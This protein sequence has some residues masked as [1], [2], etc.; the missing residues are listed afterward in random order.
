MRQ[1]IPINVCDC[2][3]D[4]EPLGAIIVHFVD[5]SLSPSWRELQGICSHME[6]T[7]SRFHFP[8]GCRGIPA[9]CTP[10]VSVVL[11]QIASRFRNG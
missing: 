4:T 7:V 6:Q 1:L 9:I 3:V 8:V 5:D 11:S 10:L 2:E